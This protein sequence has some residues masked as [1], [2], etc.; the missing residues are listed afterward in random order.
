MNINF[1]RIFRTLAVSSL[2]FSLTAGASGGDACRLQ[3]LK[4]AQPFV[5][6]GD[7]LEQAYVEAA[8]SKAFTVLEPESKEVNGLYLAVE[9]KFLK[10]ETRVGAFFDRDALTVCFLAPCPADVP[11]QDGDSVECHFMMDGKTVYRMAVDLTGKVTYGKYDAMTL[12]DEAWSAGGAAAV[13]R[14]A[15]SF[16]AELRIPFA[17]FGGK[18]RPTG[19]WRC[20]F[21][22]RGASCGGLSS[23]APTNRE[24]MDPEKFGR[25]VF[26]G[27]TEE[28]PAEPRPENV[29]KTVF[30]WGED[31]WAD[32]RPDVAA[33]LDRPELARLD[34]QG[35]R[36]TRA[37][38]AFRVSNR[39]DRPALY[40]LC[41]ASKDAD[42]LSRVRLREVGYLELRGG[43]V[44]PDPIFE[45]PIG[46]VL[47]IPAKSTAIVWVD[48]DCTGL[49][50]GKHSGRIRC[51][52][53]Y[54]GFDEK[55][56]KLV[57]AVEKPDLG[58]IKMP[59]WYYSLGHRNQAAVSTIVKDYGFNV[60]TLA[61]HVH[62][63]PPDKDGNFD[64]SAL[65]DKIA[66]LAA[67]GVP[68]DELRLMLYSM[69]PNWAGFT[70]ADGRKLGFL[71]P[72]WKE[73]YGKRLK[74]VI[75]HL[76]E[77]HGIGYDRVFLSTNDEPKGD[78]DDPK[79]KAYAAFKGAEFARSVDPKLRIFCNPWALEPDYLQRYLDTFDILEPYLRRFL[80]GTEDP[81]IAKRFA[82]SGKEIWSYT[83]YV[84]QN[85]VHQY[86]RVFWG[87]MDYGWEGPA[88]VYGFAAETGDPFN[89]YDGGK[90]TS[91]YNSGYRND[92]TGQQTPSRRLEA[93]YQ[94]LV[95]MKLVKW[96]RREIAARKVKGEDLSVQDAELKKIIHAANALRSDL[97]SARQKIVEFSRQFD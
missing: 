57:L 45:L 69:F 51:V 9:Q 46:S 58:E 32:N 95:D 8:W 2:G 35:F 17:A 37:I 72:A 73:E 38:G 36:G 88:A 85:T 41:V 90:T 96:C 61:P 48:V 27:T 97:G 34:L 44:I 52:P 47:R 11:A 63:C 65:D 18:V 71:E 39:T 33:P 79:T 75:A 77:K 94:G 82:E 16:S 70:T 5:I 43:E 31:P 14:G 62:Y 50:T 10:A 24:Q 29:G 56:L 30:L 84:K 25:L 64:F 53:G 76:R 89:S 83:I 54:S 42:F 74:A 87:N 49:A 60:F 67:A 12:K 7:T 81:E 80:N 26:E 92:R 19:V 20:N 22:R 93:W 3:A 86:R 68:K 28:K 6:D 1:F 91:D 21:V 66:A 40:N 78:P 59:V 13:K 15:K 55:S 23:W 4:A